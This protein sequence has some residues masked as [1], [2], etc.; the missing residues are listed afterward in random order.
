M[1]RESMKVL[2]AMGLNA[3]Q[4]R[5]LT[6]HVADLAALMGT[7]MPSAAKLMAMA[8]NNG[9]GALARSGVALSQLLAQAGQALPPALA[10]CVWPRPS[11]ADSRPV[12]GCWRIVVAGAVS[13]L[14]I[15][16]TPRKV[17]YT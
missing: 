17:Q 15:E 1:V 10:T 16:Q 4:T 7:D 12:F 11:P 8:I 6:P 14:C 5:A 3:A 2:G 13:V 9:S